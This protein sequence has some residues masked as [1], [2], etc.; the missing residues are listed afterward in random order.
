MPAFPD[1]QAVAGAYN[2]Q[3]TDL[4][5]GYSSGHSDAHLWYHGTIDSRTP[6]SDTEAS[7]NASQRTNWWTAYELFGARAG[8]LNSVI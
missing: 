2:R 3:L 5:G 8:F 4:S 6:A 7:I 1:G